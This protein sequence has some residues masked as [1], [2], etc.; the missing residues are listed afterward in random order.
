M[1]SYED[2]Y[3]E[4]KDPPGFIWVLLADLV[5]AWCWIADHAKRFRL[6]HC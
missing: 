4:G 6:T 3:E 2:L 5:I 1:G